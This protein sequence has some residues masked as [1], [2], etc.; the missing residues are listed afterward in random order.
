MPS[1]GTRGKWGCSCLLFDGINKIIWG[2]RG[3][4]T[5]PIIIPRDSRRCRNIS[6]TRNGCGRS[7]FYHS[8]CFRY[9]F[10]LFPKRCRNINI[11]NSCGRS[12]SFALIASATRFYIYAL[13]TF[14]FRTIHA[15]YGLSFVETAAFAGD[16][17]W[18][19]FVEI[20]A[21]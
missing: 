17:Y 6:N 18:E 5:V 1:R 15:F 7:A 12:A 9:L 20:L 8:H 14:F 2:S 4:H 21:S 11:R 19:N 3:C 16:A 10:M 13:L